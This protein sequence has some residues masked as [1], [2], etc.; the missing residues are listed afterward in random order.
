MNKNPN[1]PSDESILLSSESDNDECYEPATFKRQK[2]ETFEI[3]V[4]PEADD[5]P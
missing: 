3:E 1:S 2:L 5:A 4:L